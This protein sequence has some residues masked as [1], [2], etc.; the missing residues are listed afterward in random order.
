MA[1]VVVTGATGFVGREAVA[2]LRSL[3]HSVISVGRGD[4][5]PNDSHWISADLLIPGAAETLAEATSA[6]ALLHLAWTT[7]HGLY[8]NDL[9]NLEWLSATIEF[10]WW[11]YP[12]P[13]PLG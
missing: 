2:S 9:A 11:C 4:R 10:L 12:P 3:G 6:D 5:T 7:R 13:T 8:W 1:R